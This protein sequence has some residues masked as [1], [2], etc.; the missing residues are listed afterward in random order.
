MIKSNFQLEK[1]KERSIL[2]CITSITGKINEATVTGF[3]PSVF[4]N[5]NSQSNTTNANND[6]IQQLDL[7]DYIKAHNERVSALSRN[8]K[9]P[10]FVGPPA[11]G[12]NQRDTIG[13]DVLGNPVV[14]GV[15]MNSPFNNLPKVPFTPD[16]SGDAPP[17]LNLSSGKNKKESVARLGYGASVSSTQTPSSATTPSSKQLAQSPFQNSF[18]KAQAMFGVSTT[19][20]SATTPSATTPS[21]TTPSATTPASTRQSIYP[22]NRQ[23]ISNQLINTTNNRPGSVENTGAAIVNKQTPIG[24]P[25]NSGTPNILSTSKNSQTPMRGDEDQGASETNQMITPNYPDEAQHQ[26]MFAGS[27]RPAD[28]TR[29]PES[30]EAVGSKIVNK[31]T[32]AATPAATPAETLPFEA[33]P[34]P[35]QRRLTPYADKRVYASRPSQTDDFKVRSS[36]TSTSSLGQRA[37]A[38]TNPSL[39]P[40]Q[41]GQSTPFVVKGPFVP[42]GQAQQKS[43][44]S[45]PD[46]NDLSPDE[47]YRRTMAAGNFNGNSISSEATM[48]GLGVD[49]V[50]ERAGQ[51]T[52]VGVEDPNYATGFPDN[53]LPAGYAKRP[54]G[55][56]NTTTGLRV[57]GSGP[58]DPDYVPFSKTPEGIR[59]GN[60]TKDERDKEDRTKWNTYHKDQD[61]KIERSN[62]RRSIA[63][64]QKQIDTLLKRGAILTPDQIRGT[65]VDEDGNP[66]TDKDGKPVNIK[67]PDLSEYPTQ[68]D[69]IHQREEQDRERQR[70]NN[71]ESYNPGKY[72]YLQEAG[73]GISGVLK[74]VLDPLGSWAQGAAREAI[75]FTKVYAPKVGYIALTPPKE[76]AATVTGRLGG[77]GFSKEGAQD[78]FNY[79]RN[80]LH[81]VGNLGSGLLAASG[82]GSKIG[83][84]IDKL[85][86]N[87]TAVAAGKNLLGAL[88]PDKFIN[89]AADEAATLTGAALYDPRMAG[90]NFRSRAIKNTK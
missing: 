74:P 58:Q 26:D 49:S 61:E 8:P 59:R 77:L 33:P 14:N 43:K 28:T 11:S 60:L 63:N 36:D 38:L 54:D 31:Q 70:G 83:G 88:Q 19:P 73:S 69:I 42:Q 81:G 32:P 21:A 29:R 48:R 6:P 80:M 30:V 57:A 68:R 37:K 51:Q 39:P 75:D 79:Y 10:N 55:V 56:Y 67:L 41:P 34:D 45:L 50:K 84:A 52:Q 87:S 66:I 3:T 22:G 64:R 13:N 16:F 12:Q 25:N 23:E 17:N 72:N 47:R 24:T 9:S 15:Q 82:V 1:E 20:S 85:N 90:M 18:D 89:A 71:N 27:G 53:K 76:L 40:L 4:N 65:D 35:G 2:D 62:K 86:L 44:P 46:I 7:S 5:R 78:R